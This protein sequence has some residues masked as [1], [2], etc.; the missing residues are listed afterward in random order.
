MSAAG[1]RG[2]TLQYSGRGAGRQASVISI[3]GKKKTAAL[4]WPGYPEDT[5]TGIVRID[6]NI[7]RNAGVTIDEKVPVKIVQAAPAESVV[8]A[9]TVPLR[10]TGGEEYLRRYMDGRVLTRGDVIEINVMGR[11]IELVAV[12]ITPG[13]ESVVIGDRT[14]IELSEKP[15]KEE[16][17]IPRV[18]Y[19]DIGGLGSEI[20]R[21]RE[22]IELPMKRP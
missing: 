10:I 15:A 12:R 5:G 21:Y 11:K 4:L 3:H 6:G 17:A 7:R 1:S 19:E 9:P 18:T 13:K 20:K 22:M 16:K 2:L 14:K 8:F